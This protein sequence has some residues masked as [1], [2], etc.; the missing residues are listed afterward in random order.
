MP[1]LRTN[2]LVCRR[3]GF[4][5][6][7]V[8]VRI[9]AGDCVALIGPNGAGKTTLLETLAGRLPAAGEIDLNGISL[10]EARRE[11]L[12]TVGY[13]VDPRLIPNVLTGRQCIE[14]MAY[15]RL[16]PASCSKAFELAGHL[17]LERL[18]VPVE[19]LSLGM[20]HKLALVLALT[21]SP[22][23]VLLDE[24]FAALDF[25][26]AALAAELLRE[27]CANGSAAILATHSLH[28]AERLANRLLLLRAGR[29]IADWDREAYRKARARG[30]E[31]MLVEAEQRA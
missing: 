14:I 28:L 9:Q 13:A 7:P 25:S 31:Q 26:S 21:G 29:V 6:G 24:V 1:L 30:L 11:A 3:Q 10:R 20:R 5:F 12:K 22:P 19:R 27:H 18:D 8:S 2:R 16:V 15:A 23:L 17:G 4:E